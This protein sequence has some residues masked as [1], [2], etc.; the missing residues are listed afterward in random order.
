MLLHD[1]MS[2]TLRELRVKLIVSGLLSILAATCFMVLLNLPDVS[3]APT[4]RIYVNP[5]ISY[6]L[7][8]ENITVVLNAEV[9]TEELF[10]WQVNMSFN[11]SVLEYLNVTEG[12]F[13]E[14]QPYGTTPIFRFDHAADGWIAFGW[15]TTTYTKGVPGNGTLAS[16]TFNVKAQ[17]ESLIDI[18]KG[19]TRLNKVYPPPP[20]PGEEPVMEIPSTKEN[21]LFTNER[22][23]PT[24]KFT[25]S[26]DTPGVEENVKFNASESIAASGLQIVSYN[27][28][29]GDG[30]NGTS[31]TVEHA[32]TT[33]GSYN[34][35]LTV[36]DNATATS[37]ITQVY[38]IN[39]MPPQWY[40][41]YG[42]QT[43]TLTVMFG[44]DVAVTRITVSS[45]EVIKGE[46]ITINV[47]VA[48]R[49]T[50]TKSFDVAAYAVDTEIEQKKPVT[51]LVS[52]DSVVKTFLWDTTNVDEGE[53]QI[54]A[55]AILEGDMDTT[56]N[57]LIYGFVTVTLPA[58]GSIPLTLII[59]AVG[60]VAVVGIVIFLFL[61]RRG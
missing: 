61:R 55:E 48:N 8:G 42:S 14:D 6:A 39:T 51:D 12:N 57:K 15:V 27:W 49:G 18:T 33:G 45:A 1:R 24:A 30:T 58:S 16:V 28:T 46:T 32:F 7:T 38:G 4:A 34:V 52:G 31:V 40:Q 21:G 35:T 9:G 36:F 43:K 41:L 5:V 19:Y 25:A 13:L 17:G 50:E 60:A 23:P 2:R 44:I 3:S 56:D 47:T 22:T 54:S 26:T 10:S 29:F 59:G 11:P 37:L 53:Y 20:P